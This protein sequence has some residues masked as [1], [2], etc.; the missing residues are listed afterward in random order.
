MKKT[1]RTFMASVKKCWNV[2]LVGFSLIT[3][4][5]LMGSGQN[6]YG[7]TNGLVLHYDFDVD[8]TNRVG[9]LPAVCRGPARKA[10]LLGHPVGG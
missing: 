7:I 5:L 3:Y 9:V 8:M 10:F 1:D 2:R 6:V 4:V